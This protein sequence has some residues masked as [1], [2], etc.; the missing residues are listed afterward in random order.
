MSAYM[1]NPEDV[2]AILSAW[3]ALGDDGSSLDR[4]ERAPWH[5][6]MLWETNWE[7]VA[8]RY[9]NEPRGEMPPYE[10]RE[11][12]FPRC[13]PRTGARYSVP[14]EFVKALPVLLKLIDHYTYQACEIPTWETSSA[15][16]FCDSLWRD[17]AI[18]LAGPAYEAATWGTSSRDP[19]GAAFFATVTP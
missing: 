3:I 18:R 2:D 15:K 19:F 12:R 11:V 9:P 7:S 14:L 10:F 16:A 4:R 17:A 6:R 1:V 5:G 13:R 8:T